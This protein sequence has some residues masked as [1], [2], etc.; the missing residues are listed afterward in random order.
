MA[1]VNGGS[2][3]LVELTAAACTF[4]LA[5]NEI[6]FAAGWSPFSCK[7]T[8]IH[9]VSF[10]YKIYSLIDISSRIR[11]VCSYQRSTF[12]EVVVLDVHTSKSVYGT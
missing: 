3:V 9:T 2:F 7:V 11:T 5:I 12:Q 10:S 1:T 6:A 8:I 4:V